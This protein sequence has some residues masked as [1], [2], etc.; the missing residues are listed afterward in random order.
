MVSR[1]GGLRPIVCATLF[2]PVLLCAAAGWCDRKAPRSR[3]AT[4][5]ATKPV[6]PSGRLDPYA[7]TLKELEI[8]PDAGGIGKFLRGLHPSPATL[9]RA[10]VLIRQLGSAV[11]RQR[12]SA[13]RELLRMPAIPAEML[14]EAARDPDIEIRS[15][16][17]H[18]LDRRTT[19]MD[20]VL[21]AVFGTIAARKLGGLAP[22]VLKAIPLCADEYLVAAAR[23]A[24]GATA[25]AQDA[26]LLRRALEGKNV[27]VRIAA[28]GV[29]AKLLGPRSPREVYPLLTDRE[30]RVAL[31]AARGLADCGDRKSLEALSRP[32]SAE[33]VR[34]RAQSAAT[35]RALTGKNFGYVPYGKP[36]DRAEAAA[37][38]KKWIDAQGAT[39]ELHFPLKALPSG[40]GDL[41]GNTLIAYGYK[42]KVEELNPAGKVVWSCSAR[43]AWAAEKLPN[44]NVLIAAYN[45]NKVQEIDR[46]GKVVWEFAANCLNAKPLAN[47]N[48][49]VADY[50]GKRAVEVTRAKKIV[51]TYQAKNNCTDVQRLPGGN[52]LVASL[53]SVEE[54]TPAGKVVWSWTAPGQIFG[55][56]RLEN[57]NTLIAVLRIV[58]GGVGTGGVME[59]APTK[60]VVWQY[61]TAA[62]DAFR[63]PN[64]NT[65]VTTSNKVLEVTPAKKVVWE[66]AGLSYG[67]ARR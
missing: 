41:H 1:A 56:R 47:G 3:P 30:P 62:V 53:N 43:G 11:W 16:A 44:G 40:V 7:A 46:K 25:R 17:Q 14:R 35:L 10:E 64:G 52:T 4:R 66:R 48:V 36:A 50:R 29:M 28:A 63:L 8:T 33:K 31:A 27:Q 39:A 34:V 38:W 21:H 18:I 2:A 20:Q 13:T 42:N 67:S 37:A 12:D 23:K 19:R 54:V 60:K 49:L 15:R 59:L 6:E 26:D 57:G 51:W 45:H 9:K 58:R 5:A 65:L 32:L 22:G 55:A 24:L 61:P